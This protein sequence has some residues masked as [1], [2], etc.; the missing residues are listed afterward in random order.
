[1]NGTCDVE[2]DS[3][4]S[5]SLLAASTAGLVS[6]TQLAAAARRI[7]AHRFSLGLFDDPRGTEY[8]Q[9]KYNSSATVH[10]AEHAAI[11]REAAQQS[12]VVAQNN[13]AVLPLKATTSSFAL[14]GPMAN[15]TDVFLG[16]HAPRSPLLASSLTSVL[17]SGGAGRGA[18]ARG[19]AAAA[20]ERPALGRDTRAVRYAH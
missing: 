7:L 16:K 13:G 18:A 8:W 2:C 14:I 6:T 9:G 12:V 17:R 4:Y 5:K 11:A 20:R 19:D 10:S 1:M 3:V 15:I